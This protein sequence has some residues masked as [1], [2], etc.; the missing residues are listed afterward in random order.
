MTRLARGALG[1]TMLGLAGCAP[2]GSAGT[3]PEPATPRGAIAPLQPTALGGFV[4]DV[5]LTNQ[6]G[7]IVRL[8][9]LRGRV[10]VVTFLYTRCPVPEMCPRLMRN[11]HQLR[12]AVAAREDV[13][14]RIH[15]LG[16][17]IDPANDTPP[18]LQAY[19]KAVL[20]QRQTFE[21]LDLVSGNVTEI[22][23][24]A[25]SLGLWH[26]PATG[27]IA[28][29]MVTGIIGADGRLVKRFPELSWDVAAA[30]AVL[31]REAARVTN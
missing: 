26:E 9:A 20:G 15:F 31:E 13:S 17:S 4:P 28:H 22:A 18:V 8:Q 19:G 10:V 24:L 27:R 16:V 7:N 23:R 25:A 21:R 5:T 1:L 3:S 14:A 6:F 30:M 12:Q 29:S 2:D 11:L